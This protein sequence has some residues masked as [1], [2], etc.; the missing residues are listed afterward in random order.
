[1]ALSPSAPSST[2]GT[3]KKSMKQGN[4][5]S[6]FSK[7]EKPS[8]STSSA[9]LSVK[10]ESSRKVAPAVTPNPTSVS[11]SSLK[12]VQTKKAELVQSVN[13]HNRAI[14]QNVKVGSYI[15]VFWPEDGA[16]L[17]YIL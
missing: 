3:N 5:F 9:L 2:K 17:F 6:F 13:H 8:S 7:K 10:G 12:C 1:M 16:F 11:E 15:A 14:V 4:L